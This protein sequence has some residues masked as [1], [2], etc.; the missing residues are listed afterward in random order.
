MN[1]SNAANLLENSVI[2]GRQS[3]S[4]WSCVWRNTKEHTHYVQGVAYD[5]LGVYLASQGT[6]LSVRV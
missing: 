4:Q 1:S 6:D 2:S 3:Q 5:P